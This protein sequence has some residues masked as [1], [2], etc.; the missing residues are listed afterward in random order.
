MKMPGA[1]TERG[2]ISCFCPYNKNSRWLTYEEERCHFDLWFLSSQFKIKW[3][4][5]FR[6]LVAKN[7]WQRKPTDIMSQ[8]RG[9]D[10]LVAKPWGGGTAPNFM[11]SSY[12]HSTSQR[13][14]LRDQT[15]YRR[16]LGGHLSPPTTMEPWR[17]VQPKTL[18]GRGPSSTK[19]GWMHL[20]EIEDRTGVDLN[21]LYICT[22]N[23]FS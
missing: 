20:S 19:D 10:H 3:A 7:M 13:H 16:T 17:D 22:L 2:C 4:H 14:C 1:Q 8:D 9:E 6:P 12:P 18:T 15:F 11:F 21:V 5:P 23:R